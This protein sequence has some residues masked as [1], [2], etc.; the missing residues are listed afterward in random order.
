[1][2]EFEFGLRLYTI[3]LSRFYFSRQYWEIGVT[4]GI[5]LGR[6]E[7]GRGCR[8]CLLSWIVRGL[9]RELNL[10]YSRGLGDCGASSVYLC[11]G[12]REEEGGYIYIGPPPRD[13]TGILKATFWQDYYKDI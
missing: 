11:F 10:G 4:P 12:N 7:E 8:S 3:C 5:F 1:M 6:N 2:K 13:L 9:D